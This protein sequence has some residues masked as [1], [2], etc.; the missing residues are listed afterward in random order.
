MRHPTA[1]LVVFLLLLAGCQSEP[2]RPGASPEETAAAKSAALRDSLAA[3]ADRI[4][5]TKSLNRL[6]AGVPASGTLSPSDATLSDGSTYDAWLYSGQ[7]GEQVTL[8]VVSSDFDAYLMLAIQDE[9][10]RRIVG[11]DDDSGTGRNAHLQLT[12]PQT[13][14]YVAVVNSWAEGSTGQYQI[15][16]E[17][18]RGGGGAPVADGITRTDPDDAGA[19]ASTQAPASSSG[20]SASE[21]TLP[22]GAS[23]TGRITS[24]DARLADG[25][26]FDRWT[27][28]AQAGERVTF[29]LR[30]SAFDA[31]LGVAQ[32]RN[33][34]TRMLG[35]DDDSAGGTDAQLTVTFPEAEVYS[36]VANTLRPG[37]AGAYTL[38]ATRAPSGGSSVPDGVGPTLRTDAGTGTTPPDAS[39]Y[40]ARYATDG[41]PADRYALLVG[42]D[43][44][45]GA[46]ADLPSSVLDVQTM[47]DVLV[48]SLG[49]PEENV[50]TITDAEATRN[51]ILTAFARHLGQAGPDGRAVF[52]FSGHGTQLD[53]NEGVTAPL[54]NESDNVDEAFAVWDDDGR[55]SSLILDDE[56]GLLTDQ[57][58]TSHAMIVLDACH[59]GT[60]TR[61]RSDSPLVEKRV[62]LDSLTNLVRPTAYLK[63]AGDTPA[64]DAS[65]TT[66]DV[67]V[68]DVLARPQRHI[69]LT[70]ARADEKALAGSG[71]R[72]KD[73]RML[74]ASAFTHFLAE[75][76]RAADASTTFA[77]LMTEVQRQTL[78]YAQSRAGQSQ[79]PQVE[80]NAQS[81]RVADF[82]GASPSAASSPARDAGSSSNA[83]RW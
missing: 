30:S 77:D 34:Q 36:V 17:S 12:L 37:E 60:G 66:D 11:R 14:T 65:A 33:G 74:E 83:G 22:L 79:T 39:Q 72:I 70:A 76:L 18:S 51:H 47:K 62:P 46:R 75:Q 35:R 67:S 15:L 13:G 38:Q 71:G 55:S 3:A 68:G 5:V 57:L 42:I 24:S 73:P 28:N 1:V 53:G 82:L 6:T 81:Q 8:S 27:Y 21:G 29:T 44:Y 43:D 78:S 50:V 16:L 2:E 49:F 45:P 59:S 56:L 63:G 4:L 52:Y 64:L 26:A 7:R 23:V 48:G 40:A 32:E 69:L 10:G 19:S 31:Y 80:G 58:T 9:S 20:S 41:D 54:D 25:S 61:G